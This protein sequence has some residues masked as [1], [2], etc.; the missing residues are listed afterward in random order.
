M[1]EVLSALIV[2]VAAVYLALRLDITVTARGRAV[3]VRVLFGKR[4]AK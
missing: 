4:E 1:S 2:V 3:T